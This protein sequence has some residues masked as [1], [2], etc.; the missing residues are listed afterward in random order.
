MN[1]RFDGMSVDSYGG[2]FGGSFDLVP[3]D[4]KVLRLD[5]EVMVVTIARVKQVAVSETRSGDTRLVYVLRPD[6]SRIVHNAQ[7]LHGL[8]LN[9]DF[10]AADLDVDE[11]TSSFPALD[12]PDFADKLKDY[13]ALGLQGDGS[14][15][16]KVPSTE[17]A[18]SESVIEQLGDLE[19]DPRFEGVAPG[20]RIVVD[21][22]RVADIDRAGPPK[23][24]VES[25]EITRKDTVL[26]GFLNE[27]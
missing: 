17:I 14:A 21:Q 3:E 18:E 6:E 27:V 26:S 15:G 10:P 9:L 12:D 16:T 20:E 25:T 4:G 23:A 8:L 11:T 7:L 24:P 5:D 13:L 1:D 2:R 22:F 19:N